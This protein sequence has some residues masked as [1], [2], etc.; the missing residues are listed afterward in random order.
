MNPVQKF[1]W[2]HAIFK[3]PL[4]ITI[5]IMLLRDQEKSGEKPRPNSQKT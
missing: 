1:L 4:I 2:Q 3:I 5:K